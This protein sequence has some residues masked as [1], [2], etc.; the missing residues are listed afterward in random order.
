MNEHDISRFNEAKQPEKDKSGTNFGVF[1]EAI[2]NELTATEQNQIIHSVIE[3]VIEHR[4]REKDH[5]IKIID[6][7]NAANDEL[8]RILEVFHQA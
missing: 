4:K 7:S 6:A 8:R 1:I 2:I 5:S 3:K